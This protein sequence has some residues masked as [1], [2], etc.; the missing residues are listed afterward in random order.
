M[1]H[2]PKAIILKVLSIIG[3]EDDKKAAAAEFIQNC[4]KQAILDLLTTLPKE[5][6]EQLKS[7]IAGVTDQHQQQTIIAS[8]VTPDQ[9][10]QALQKAS[11]AAFQGL[12]EAVVP[13]L[14]NEQADKLQTYLS[15]LTTP[16]ATK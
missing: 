11:A 6:Q 8:Y 3:Y 15:S 5:K 13:T 7:Q 10:Q 2:D 14:S 9:H 1:Q 16:V 12:L 4:E